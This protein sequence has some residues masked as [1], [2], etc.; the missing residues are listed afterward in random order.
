MGLT[1]TGLGKEG[2][3]GT[4]AQGGPSGKWAARGA[5]LCYGLS[6][7]AEPSLRLWGP[8]GGTQ[9]LDCSMWDL[10]S[11]TGDRTQAPCVGNMES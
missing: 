11:L 1:V 4:C 5:L 7:C 3:A 2:E 9:A 8:W 10:S 6:G